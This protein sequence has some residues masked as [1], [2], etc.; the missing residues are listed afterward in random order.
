MLGDVETAL[1]L[2]S[3]QGQNRQMSAGTALRLKVP[4]YGDFISNAISELCRIEFQTLCLTVLGDEG[5]WF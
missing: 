3:F 1:F 2:K 5:P 4:V